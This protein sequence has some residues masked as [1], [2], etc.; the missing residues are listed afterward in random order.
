MKNRV[1]ARYYGTQDTIQ[2]S[3]LV[4][5]DSGTM[6]LHPQMKT[7]SVRLLKNEVEIIRMDLLPEDYNDEKQGF[8]VFFI[9]PPVQ[10]HLYVVF[11]VELVD[12][13][14]ST[15]RVA[16][17]LTQEVPTDAATNPVI[18][19]RPAKDF[20]NTWDAEGRSRSPI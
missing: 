11:D 8:Y 1:V 4:L 6:S 20:T 13:K 5:D 14:T 9:H 3:S 15:S 7:G 19:V 12:G 10:H 2:V 18:P 17:S 16:V